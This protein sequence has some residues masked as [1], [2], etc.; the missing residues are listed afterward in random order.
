MSCGCARSRLQWR[1]TCR[2][3]VVPLGSAAVEEAVVEPTPS[4]RAEQ[5]A[6]HAAHETA[7]A[8]AARTVT[9]AGVPRLAIAAGCGALAGS[10]DA[11]DHREH[12]PDDGD[13]NQSDAQQA[14][15][16]ARREERRMFGWSGLG[17]RRGVL[18][19]FLPDEIRVHRLANVLNTFQES[20]IK[21][22]ILE[23]FEQQIAPDGRGWPS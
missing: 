21:F 7:A 16:V 13:H 17:I 15:P 19:F 22:L 6:E 20:F 4:R 1:G 8:P 2:A 3:A 23:A 9:I 12:D 14:H 10:T 5:T 18:A 11:A